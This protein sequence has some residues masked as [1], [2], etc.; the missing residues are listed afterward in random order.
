MLDDIFNKN[1]TIYLNFWC[2]Y[3]IIS[4]LITFYNFPKQ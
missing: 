4:N 3:K 1:N 2:Y